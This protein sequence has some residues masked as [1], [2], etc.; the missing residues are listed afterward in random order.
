MGFLRPMTD[1]GL[2]L[3]IDEL[4][5]SA[6]CLRDVGFDIPFEQ[7]TKPVKK[8]AGKRLLMTILR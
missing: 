4:A 8:S 5:K 6:D 7:S 1:M 3:P 2:L